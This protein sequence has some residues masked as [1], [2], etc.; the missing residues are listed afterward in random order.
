MLVF[1]WFALMLQ[2]SFLHFFPDL[3]PRVTFVV[4]GVCAVALWLGDRYLVFATT[5]TLT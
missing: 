4:I 3:S 2:C 1:S 5:S